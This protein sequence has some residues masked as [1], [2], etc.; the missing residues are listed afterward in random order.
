MLVIRAA[1]MEAFSRYALTQFEKAQWDHFRE[2]YPVDCQLAGEVSVRKLI[3]HGAAK[4]EAAGY[5]TQRQ[6]SLWI[7][8]Q[9]MLGVDFHIDPQ[10]PW[11][12]VGLKDASFGDATSRIEAVFANT[13][14]YLEQT[15][16]DDCTRLSRAID[17]LRGWDPGTAPDYA[18]E[19]WEAH[20]CSLIGEIYPEKLEVQGYPA[21]LELIRS[22]GPKA[23]NFWLDRQSG[24]A[25]F[26][27]FAFFLGSGFYHD[28]LFPWAAESLEPS[29]D[30]SEAERSRRLFDAGL[31]YLGSSAITS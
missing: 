31:Q 16:G 20:I 14:G 21:T 23:G 27:L 26:S 30:T 25:I 15:A 4:A 7:G 11:A 24:P 28:P 5:A 2:I 18:G 3:R 12:A 29:Q 10:V 1:Q 19:Q 13:I 22:A 8:L 9:F 6:I 17:R